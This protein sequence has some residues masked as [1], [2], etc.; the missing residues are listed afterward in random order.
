[1]ALHMTPLPTLI[2]TCNFNKYQCLVKSSLKLSVLR[3][4]YNSA[5]CMPQMHLITWHFLLK[6]LSLSLWSHFHLP[7][8][9]FPPASHLALQ[10]LGGSSGRG[11][12]PSSRNGVCLVS[13]GALWVDYSLSPPRP[14]VGSIPDK[15]SSSNLRYEPR[16]DLDLDWSQNHVGQREWGWKQAQKEEKGRGQR[17]K[18]ICFQVWLRVSLEGSFWKWDEVWVVQRIFKF[19]HNWVCLRVSN[20]WLILW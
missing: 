12:N 16:R 6:N 1:M 9:E 2:E 8:T 18:L 3:Q 10:P 14:L 17:G 13:S 20:R 5:R 4:E 7:T 11:L 15:E 19:L